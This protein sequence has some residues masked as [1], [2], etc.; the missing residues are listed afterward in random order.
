[1][2]I[3]NRDRLYDRVRDSAAFV[4]HRACANDAVVRGSMSLEPSQLRACFAMRGRRDARRRNRII[5]TRRSLPWASRV[6]RPPSGVPTPS[7]S[8]PM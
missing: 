5:A 2:E 6:A 8:G 3:L 1:M 7:R 4:A